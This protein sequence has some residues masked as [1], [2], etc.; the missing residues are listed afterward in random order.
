MPGDPNECRAH[1]KKCAELASRTTHPQHKQ[2]LT[3]LAQSWTKIALD[4]EQ[5]HALMEVCPP[6]LRA[7]DGAS[8]ERGA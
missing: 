4:L 6:P 1:A 5:A 8:P 3:N 2:L 7:G